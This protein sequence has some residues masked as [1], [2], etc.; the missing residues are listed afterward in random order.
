MRR[1]PLRRLFAGARPAPERIFNHNHWFRGHNN[2]RYAELLPRLERLDSYSIVLPEARLARGAA[3]RLLHA[4]R[5][6]RDAA[7]FAA[8]SR[9]YRSM[10]TTDNAQIALFAGPVVADVD[11]PTFSPEEVALLRRPNLVAYV[12]TAERAAR[13]FV[14]L[15]VEKPAHVVPQ[16]VSLAAFSEEAVR[17]VGRRSRR[18]GELVVGY[19]AAWLLTEGDRGGAN[20]LYNVDHLLELWDAIHERVPHARLWLLGGASA[21]VERRLAGRDDVLLLGRVPRE[22]LLAYVGNFDVALYPRAADQG[23]RAAKVG[24]YLG[25]GVPTVS[26]D[27]AVTEDLRETGA[28]VLVETPREFVDAVARLAA[29]DGER[30]RLAQAA[31]AAGRARDWDVLAREYNALLDRWLPAATLAR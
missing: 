12:V 16:G 4:T 24:E 22:E 11:D 23:I 21:R 20:P 5:R 8:A 1:L 29:D 17:E 15:G 3:Y 14:E 25:A 31:A 26:Y 9:R 2:P 27:Y 13:R 30:R 7:V 28:G 19:M 18:D 10:F 6:P